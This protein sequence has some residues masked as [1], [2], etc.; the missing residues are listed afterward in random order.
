MKTVTSRTA[1]ALAGALCALVLAPAVAAAAP[2]KPVQRTFASAKAAA[3]ALVAAAE[4]F[5][6]GALKEILGP[7]GVDLV[8]TGGLRPG[9]EPGDRLRRDGAREARRRSRPADPK[10]ATVSVGPGD[11]PMPIPIV[12]DGKRWRLDAEAGREE[13]FIRRIGMNELE[14]IAVCRTF[15]EAQHEYAS[16]KRDGSRV[17]QYAQKV[18]AT[19]GRQDGLAWQNADGTWSG[20]MAERDRPRRRARAITTSGSPTAA[21]TSRS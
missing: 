17:N 2:K 11:W 21:T 14:A 5:D 18:V 7:D 1:T 19:P 12:S 9:Q 20:P 16:E 3:E 8:V 13:V 4:K 15:V 10:L 6:V